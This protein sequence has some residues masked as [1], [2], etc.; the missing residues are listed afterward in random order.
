MIIEE[1]VTKDNQAITRRANEL[2][3]RLRDIVMFDWSP[4]FVI[5]LYE[6]E[7]CGKATPLGQEA[8][9]G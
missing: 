2:G 7:S 8:K 9:K 6:Q 1:R 5:M 4:M 3:L